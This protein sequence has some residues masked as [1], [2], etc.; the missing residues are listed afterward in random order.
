MGV[1]RL[2]TNMI[3]AM[4]PFGGVKQSGLG[5]ELGV[6]AL[7]EYTEPKFAY[8]DLTHDYFPGYPRSVRT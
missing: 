5:R 1:G 6:D 2:G 7:D 3:N 8:I 4:Y